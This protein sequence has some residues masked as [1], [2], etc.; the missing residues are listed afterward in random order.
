MFEM[1]EAFDAIKDGKS[2]DEVVSTINN[3]RDKVY[4]NLFVDNPSYVAERLHPF[5]RTIVDAIKLRV[6]VELFVD[7]GVITPTKG[8]SRKRSGIIDKMFYT[9]ENQF[10]DKPLVAYTLFTDKPEIGDELAERM[11]SFNLVD[12]P[13]VPGGLATTALCPAIGR[14]I[15]PGGGGVFTYIP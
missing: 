5:A 1:I 3:A 2:I 4:I 7:E 12:H 14:Y 8:F 6:K 9:M 10:G 13:Y 15:G 11:Q